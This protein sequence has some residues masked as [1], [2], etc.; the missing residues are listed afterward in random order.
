MQNIQSQYAKTWRRQY[1]NRHQH[2]HRRII[3]PHMGWSIKKSIRKQPNKW[4]CIF[5]G[6]KIESAKTLW[7]YWRPG[8]K[9]LGDYW[10]KR[11]SGKH[12]ENFRPYIITS[13]EY[14][15]L[16]KRVL[17]TR[18]SVRMPLVARVYYNWVS[19]STRLNH[20]T[21]R[22]RIRDDLTQYKLN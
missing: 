15:D 8:T 4:T 6:C 20:D 18:A 12:H 10:M 22:P 9:Q 2:P 19:K 16:L 3:L 21:N 11:H 14:L 7:I 5:I 17:A 1:I 13:K